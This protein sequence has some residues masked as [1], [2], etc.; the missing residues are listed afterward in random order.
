MKPTIAKHALLLTFGAIALSG[1]Q[2][3]APHQSADAA[4]GKGGKTDLRTLSGLDQGRAH[5]RAQNWG[6]AIEAFNVALATGE[7][8]AASYNGLGVAYARIGRP[9]LA[10][11][12][13]KKASISNPDNPVYSRNLVLL[14]DSPDFNL[15]AIN[16]GER[17]LAPAAQPAPVAAPRQAAVL[18]PEPGKL[19]RD[20]KGQFSLVTRPMDAPGGKGLRSAGPL[21]RVASRNP[22][23]KPLT[24]KVSAADPAAAAK[25]PAEAEPRKPQRKTV[26]LITAPAAS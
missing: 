10:Y 19:H 3:L 22:A 14:M 5:L 2:V 21:P 7:D 16:R 1:C 23:P 8:P 12:F 20:G 24:A 26:S 9:D 13:F 11:R 25:T 17:Q 6:R 4:S 18:P 15:A